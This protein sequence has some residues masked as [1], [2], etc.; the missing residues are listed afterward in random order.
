MTLADLSPE[1]FKTEFRAAKDAVESAT[2]TLYHAEGTV[3]PH[4]ARY[5]EEAREEL[6][7]AR[8]VFKEFRKERARRIAIRHYGRGHAC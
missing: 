2:A 6:R 3:G 8:D 4:R 7:I 5:V 1:D